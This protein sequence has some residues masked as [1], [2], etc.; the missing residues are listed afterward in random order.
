M[1]THMVCALPFAPRGECEPGE[2]VLIEVGENRFE[3]AFGDVIS[4]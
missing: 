4:P 3:S 1:V 2:G